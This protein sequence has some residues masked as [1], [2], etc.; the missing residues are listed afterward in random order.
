VAAALCFSRP[1]SR[2]VGDPEGLALVEEALEHAAHATRRQ[3]VQ[4]EAGLAWEL[5]F[6]DPARARHLSA[7]AVRRARVL[8]DPTTLAVA[9]VARRYAIWTADA[10]P[11][12]LALGDE[13][14]EL[15]ASIDSPP[16]EVQGHFTR[17]SA[18]HELGNLTAVEAEMAALGRLAD[19]YRMPVEAAW[20]SA[21]RAM[22]LAL[23]GNYDEAAVEL[24][25]ATAVAE[26]ANDEELTVQLLPLQVVLH[27]ER[28]ELDEALGLMRVAAGARPDNA[29]IESSIL[30]TRMLGG[31]RP[32][33]D[34]LARVVE[35]LGDEPQ[36]WLWVAAVAEAAQC[37]HRL[38]DEAAAEALLQRL[39]PYAHADRV[40]TCGPT[41]AFG[42]AGYFAGLA[43]STAGRVDDAVELLHRG[44]L[45][46]ERIGARP[47][48][49]RSRSALA[50]VL[51]RRDRPGDA[52]EVAEL[53]DGARALAAELGPCLATDE[54]ADAVGAPRHQLTGQ[55]TA[56]EAEVLALAAGG[57]TNAAIAADLH[58]SVKS[59]ER[60]LS[61]IYAKL[62]TRNR[63]EA[64]AWA[65][66][67]GLV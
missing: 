14:L 24:G 16:L 18:F 66:R 34:E 3:R 26:A 49:L 10:V 62:G 52:T 2:W 20:V 58:L 54:L 37:A 29:L 63:A 38:G 33:A 13:L 19:R 25:R 51:A 15:A 39:R 40:V 5:Q 42:A 7:V 36:D 9:L 30:H 47:W 4:L 28:G 59:I 35:L 22:L 50:D 43:A 65:V 6:V 46:N 23:R 64:T 53:R 60:H 48:I 31:E 1:G 8:D 56:R 41:V 45:V 12:L 44:L 32:G 55:L 67:Q 61:N 21:N 11:E 17:R 27:R 57:H